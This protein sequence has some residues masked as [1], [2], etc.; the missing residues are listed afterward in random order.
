MA[1]PPV[2]PPGGAMQPPMKKGGKVKKA[3]KTM[4]CGGK[5]KKK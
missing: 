4:K 1:G 5:A 2:A 3:K